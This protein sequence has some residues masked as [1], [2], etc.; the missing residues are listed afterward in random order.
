MDI[1]ELDKL[2]LFFIFVIPGFIS[3]KIY[4]L[5]EPSTKIDS[6]KVVIDAIA[7]SSI[8]Y[9]LLLVP[10][11][12]VERNHIDQTHPNWYGVFYL[13]VLFIAPVAWALIWKYLR[14]SNFLQKHI[15]HPTSK[16]WDYVFSQRQ[17]YWIKVTLTNGTKVGGKFAGKSFASSTPS[18]E[19]IYLEETWI[20]N[21]QGGFEKVKNRSAGI[22]IMSKEIS[23]LE[24]INYEGEENE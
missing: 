24:L 3:I 20:L 15:P 12:M 23:Y 2:I 17:P 4:D 13:F 5:I 1:W 18:E 19:Q 22:I 7:Y 11:L 16:P 8:N 9:A 10:I 21:D 14:T 6:S